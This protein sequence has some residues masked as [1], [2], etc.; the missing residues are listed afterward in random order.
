LKSNIANTS[1]DKPNLISQLFYAY[2]IFVVDELV[3]PRI[4]VAIIERT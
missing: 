3:I 2:E 1:K 4:M